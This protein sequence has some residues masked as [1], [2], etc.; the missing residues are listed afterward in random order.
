MRFRYRLEGYD[1]DWVEAGTRRV[2]YFTNLPPGDY[3]FRVMASN[4]D[5]VWSAATASYHFRLRPAWWQTWWATLLFAGAALGLVYAGVRLRL[6]AL[7]RRNRALEAKIGERTVQLA[8][9]VQELTASEERAHASELKALEASH[10]KST[11]LSNMS[12]EL[13]TP[14]TAILGFVQLVARDKTLSEAH[15]NRLSIVL[16]SGEHL[17]ALINDVLSLAKIEAGRM[18]LNE[19]AFDL[20]ELLGSVEDMLRGRAKGTDVELVFDRGE[21]VPRY[22]VGDEGKL[23]QILINLIGNSMKFTERGHVTLRVR[24]EDRRAAFEVEDTGKGIAADELANLFETFVQTESGRQAKEGTGLGLAICRN[25]VRLMGGDIEVTSEVGKG[26]TFWFEIDLPEAS[27]AESGPSVP[28]LAHLERGQEFRV[29]VVDDNAESRALFG[30]LL[31][32]AGYEVREASDGKAG[33]DAWLEWRP[34]LVCMDIRM[35][36]MDG[37]AATR[38]IRELEGGARATAIIGLT[39][40]AFKHERDAILAAGCDDFVS[41]PFRD[42]EA[43]EKIAEHL[44]A[45]YVYEDAA[46]PPAPAPAVTVERLAAVPHDVIARLKEAAV[47][48][49]VQAASLAIEEVRARDAAL[50][51]GLAGLVANLA[52]DELLRLVEQVDV[53]PTA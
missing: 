2:A 31:R 11:F 7:E 28:P 4:G 52:L 42:A 47:R 8:E 21:S 41:K 38:R 12:H 40:S 14:L 27:A 46:A 45:K 30:D 18:T 16:R 43:L 1:D 51:D 48:G 34:H 29:L 25:F 26:S 17:L 24:W 53:E 23:R 9:K 32:S 49:S 33:V 3:T 5:G 39:A 35:P 22:V 37:Y 10:A 44:G 50:A 19:R 20:H 13:R 6:R 36:V 15:Q